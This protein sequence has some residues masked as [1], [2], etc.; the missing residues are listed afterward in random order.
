MASR[1]A[2]KSKTTKAR[3]ARAGKSAPKKKS[4]PAARA[5]RAPA[6]KRASAAPTLPYHTVTPFLSIKGAEKAI[7]FYKQAFGAHERARMPG[8]EGTIMHAEL[9]IGD[10]TIM[11]SD[12]IMGP[13][14]RAALHVYVPDCDTLFERA[15][16]AGGTVKMPMAD[17]F[18]GDR[19]GQLED[20]FGNLWSIATHKEDVPAKEMERRAAEAAQ[21]FSAPPPSE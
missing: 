17:M 1:A 20:P 13:A 18:W 9:V 2:R 10:S 4:S 11:L 8:P 6:R 7:D 12:A 21:N 5:K 15:I 3:P 14:T 19:Y 16:S